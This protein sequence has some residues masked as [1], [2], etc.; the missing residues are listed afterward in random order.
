MRILRFVA[1]GYWGLVACT[2]GTET[3]NPLTA[4]LSVAAHSTDPD[5]VG[6][7]AGSGVVVDQAWV[8]LSDIRF[9]PAGAC[10]VDAAAEVALAGPAVAEL[11]AGLSFAEFAPMSD[12][13]CLV[14]VPFH[15]VPTLP[16]TAPPELAGNSIVVTGMR[17]DGVPFRIV[18][19]MVLRLGIRGPM[20]RFEVNESQRVLVVGLDV[21]TWLAGVDLASLTPQPDGTVLV[22]ATHDAATLAAFETNVLAS[23]DLFHDA[24]EDGHVSSGE[25]RVAIHH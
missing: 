2:S 25:E 21:A 18:S 14:E 23:A 1:I 22:D 12:A 6:V 11:V 15:P 4:E 3:G 17:A 10:D 9:W 16:E 7:A 5:A 8:A 19:A 13:Y 20:D 24:N